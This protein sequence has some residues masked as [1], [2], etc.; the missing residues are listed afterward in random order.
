MSQ[1]NNNMSRNR[2]SSSLSFNQEN[3]SFNDI[4]AFIDY[5][6][7]NSFIPSPTLSRSSF[8]SS[9]SSTPSMNQKVTNNNHLSATGFPAPSHQYDLHTQQTGSLPVNSGFYPDFFPPAA[10]M[11]VSPHENSFMQLDNDSSASLN[12]SSGMMPAYF[13]PESTTTGD[14]S[15]NFVNPSLVLGTSPIAMDNLESSVKIE[16]PT[17]TVPPVGPTAPPMATAGRFYAGIHQHQAAYEQQQRAIR[18]QQQRQA[19]QQAP[20][21][22]QQ[23]LKVAPKSNVDER[24]DKILTSMKSNAPHPSANGTPP[25]LPHIAKLKKEEDEMDE[26]ERLLASEE[27]KKLTSKE[28]R[29]LRNKVSARAFRSR[30]KEYI[31]HLEQEVATK[32]N[33]AT[34]LQHENTRLKEENNK[35]SELTR[36]LLSSPAFSVFLDA[37]QPAAQNDTLEQVP[38]ATTAPE[39]KTAPSNTDASLRPNTRKDVNPNLVPVSEDSEWPLAYNTWGTNSPQVF[40]VLELPQGPPSIQDLSGKVVEDEDW[41]LSSLPVADGFF[42]IRNEKA[43]IMDHFDEDEYEAPEDLFDV[44]EE[45]MQYNTREETEVD[46]KK[47]LD[48]LFPGTGVEALLERLEMIAGGQAQPEDLFEEVAV[49][50]SLEIVEEKSEEIEESTLGEANR[51]LD[52][53]EGIYRRIGLVVGG[54]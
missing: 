16:V 4:D 38:N 2:S 35:L 43:G 24:V 34:D 36:M 22:Q 17:V 53:A 13:Y 39:P 6:G 3:S 29:Q 32:T 52:A 41:K 26:D 48:E 19:Q 40:S 12:G 18:E 44:Y 23:Q 45:E 31:T 9:Q 11:S 28:R 5:D 15:A 51:M 14:S 27:G 33:E 10:S 21:S 49:E 42:P 25:V 8:S 37:M 50:K 7:P 46:E 20:L 47:T 54:Q 1:Q 30:R